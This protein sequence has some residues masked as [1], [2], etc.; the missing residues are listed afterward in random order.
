[1]AA[2]FC[3]SLLNGRPAMVYEDGEQLRDFVHVRDVVQAN[4]L[5]LEHDGADGAAVNIG[6][7]TPVSIADVACCLG[8]QLASDVAPTITGQLRTGD[9]RHCF[10][11]I[12]RA[13]ALVGFVPSTSFTAGLCDLVDWVRNRAA[14]DGAERVRQEL[15]SRGLVR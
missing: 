10:A 3:A 15:E 7:G 9:I 12:S 6:S 1:M 4:M 2:I 5:A 13:R 8:R 11:D 14:H